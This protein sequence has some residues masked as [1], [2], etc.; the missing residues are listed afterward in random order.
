ML[1]SPRRTPRHT[2]RL[3]PAVAAGLAALTLSAC[4]DA[5]ATGP[6]APIATRHESSEGRGYF[7]RYV[8]LGTSIS[9]GVA[10]DGLIA[11][12][13]RQSWPAQ[14]ARLGHREMTLPLIALPG[15]NVPL[16]APLAS[17]VRIDG[18]PATGFTCA[19]NEEGVTLPANNVAVDGTRVAEALFGPNPADPQRV[20]KHSRI[21]PAGMTQVGAMKAQ[22]PKLVSVEMGANELLGVRGGILV[23]Y[24]TVVPFETFRAQY[25]QLLDEVA[26]V[27]PKAVVLAGLISDVGTFPAFRA[28]KELF[29]NRAEL[30][31]YGIVI[32]PGCGGANAGNLIFAPVKIPTL[33][34]MARATGQPQFYDCADVPGT[35]DYTLTPGDRA[36]VNTLLAQMNAHIQQQAEAR[37][38]AHFR[39]GELYEAPGVR[40]EYSAHQQF[41]SLDAP[42]GHFISFDGYHP[43]ALGQTMLAQAAARALNAKYGMEIPTLLEEVVAGN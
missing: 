2:P 3:A 25:D 22:N 19:P 15:C 34:A 24:V 30:V 40:V 37:G 12:S 23:P 38:W 17:G 11:A 36:T 14:L 29:D 1:R 6:Q 32:L 31:A 21:L 20:A 18:S 28:G 27:Q 8:A 41:R 43:S 10:S 16:R 39:L 42:Y 33:A 9:A 26:S 5:V 7:Q 35:V 13:Q 4:G